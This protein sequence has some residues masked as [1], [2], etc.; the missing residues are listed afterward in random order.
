MN[1]IN[2]D[3][4]RIE[5][6]VKPR[7]VIEFKGKIS[8]PKTFNNNFNQLQNEII[9]LCKSNP[10]A[11]TDYAY[12]YLSLLERQGII[13]ILIDTKIPS[14]ESVDRLR[15]KLFEYAEYGNNELSFL[16]KFKDSNNEELNKESKKYYRSN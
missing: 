7:E 5:R 12:L 13:K 4:F 8:N 14:P 6:E 16:L 9:N 2:N 10:R 15:R 1:L 3:K 11:C